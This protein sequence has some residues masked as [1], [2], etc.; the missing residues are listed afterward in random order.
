MAQKKILVCDDEPQLR[1]MLSTR[2][3]A[4]GYAVIEAHDG[5]ECM[6]ILDHERLDLIV[7]DLRMPRA[8]GIDVLRKLKEETRTIPVVVLS[9]NYQKGEQKQIRNL[10][11]DC[12]QNK[13]FAINELIRKIGKLCST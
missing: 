2:L 11:Y 13:P 6:R 1:E 3:V 7:L 5:I 10:G 8:S 4:Q 9:G 12:F